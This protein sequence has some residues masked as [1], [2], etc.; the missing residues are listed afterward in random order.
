KYNIKQAPAYVEEHLDEDGDYIIDV[1]DDNDLILRC[2]IQSR[3]SNAVKHK[4]WI[5]Y[6]FSGEPIV[7][8]Y[9][10]CSAGAMTVGS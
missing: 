5:Q 2:T 1:G 9:C 10:T 8:W 7:S 4:T 3:H 6:S